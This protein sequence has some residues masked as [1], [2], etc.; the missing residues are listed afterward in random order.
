MDFENVGVAKVSRTSIL[1]MLLWLRFR[2]R[3]RLRAGG[4]SGPHTVRSHTLVRKASPYNPPA[5]AECWPA[6]HESERPAELGGAK[7]ARRGPARHMLF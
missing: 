7:F 6:K 5:S 2:A 1:K 3:R 4:K